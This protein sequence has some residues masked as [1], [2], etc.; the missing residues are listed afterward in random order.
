MHAKAP[1]AS[2]VKLLRRRGDFIHFDR[3][4]DKY[5]VYSR[6]KNTVYNYCAG[7]APLSSNS[8]QCVA[9]SQAPEAFA[10]VLHSYVEK[11]K[12]N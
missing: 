4:F 9:K 1:G 10:C 2:A 11:Q 12:K 3:D 8:L 5:N 7:V 6:P